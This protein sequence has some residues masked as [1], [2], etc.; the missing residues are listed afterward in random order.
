MRCRAADIH[1]LARGVNC[2]ESRVAASGH[3]FFI[4]SIR[5]VNRERRLLSNCSMQDRQRYPEHCRHHLHLFD[6][7][8]QGRRA[9]AAAVVREPLNPT[10]QNHAKI[11]ALL[12]SG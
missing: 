2:R 8:E 4:D 1:L 5:C 6:L 9:D 3:A 11:R 10:L 7:L 12:G